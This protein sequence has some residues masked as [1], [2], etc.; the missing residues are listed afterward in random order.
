MP[1]RRMAREGKRATIW[2]EERDE[3]PMP[4]RKKREIRYDDSDECNQ[5]APENASSILY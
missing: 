1:K 5:R 3:K 2:R 4:L